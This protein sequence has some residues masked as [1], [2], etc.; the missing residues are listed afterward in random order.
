M[1]KLLAVILLCFNG[2]FAMESANA[3]PVTLMIL[4]PLALEA[5][6]EASPAV[7]AGM[8]GSSG[9]LSEIGTDMGNILRLPLGV[10]QATAGIPLGML[11]D[12]LENV[13]IG[14]VAPLQLVGDVLILPFS[15]WTAGGQ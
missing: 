7:I 5:A 4:A 3:E 11:G 10:V 13:T 2:F 12:G 6:K 8:R 15:F 14:L 1:K 9:Q